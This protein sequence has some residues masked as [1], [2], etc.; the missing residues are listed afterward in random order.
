MSSSAAADNGMFSSLFWVGA[1]I[2]IGTAPGYSKGWFFLLR[3][4]R[5]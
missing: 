4:Y 2:R 1:I 3:F 5:L